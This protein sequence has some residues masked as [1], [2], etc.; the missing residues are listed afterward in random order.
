MG[1]ASSWQAPAA[2]AN[3][4]QAWQPSWWPVP[5]GA[6]QRHTASTEITQACS[7]GHSAAQHRSSLTP[8]VHGCACRLRA[9]CLELQLHKS[10]AALLIALLKAATACC[11]L[12]CL[13]AQCAV[14]RVQTSRSFTAC[15]H[16]VCRRLQ[17]CSSSC[18]K[19]ASTR[20]RL[21]HWRS[22]PRN[23]RLPSRAR[24]GYAT[25]RIALASC[26]MLDS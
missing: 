14:R 1:E 12:L 6:A 22:C 2:R 23:T 16:W 24:C 7:I 5:C 3:P 15:R 4:A 21:Q 8:D 20:C 10:T 13:E 26:M 17:L 11:R 18:W 9:C 25:L 19:T